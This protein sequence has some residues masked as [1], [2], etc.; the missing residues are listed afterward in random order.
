MRAVLAIMIGLT[1]A[2]CGARHNDGMGD[3]WKGVK[4][5]QERR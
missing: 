2:G 1:L 5:I 3:L 4:L